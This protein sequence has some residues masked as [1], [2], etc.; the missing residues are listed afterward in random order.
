[1]SR[2][3]LVPLVAS[4]LVHALLASG[5]RDVAFLPDLSDAELLP[6]VD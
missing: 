3:Y 2:R 6:K 4:V 1:M 5:V